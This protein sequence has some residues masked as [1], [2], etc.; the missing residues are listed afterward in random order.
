MHAYSSDTPPDEG[1][2]GGRCIARNTNTSST[3]KW[4]NFFNSFRGI[5]EGLDGITVRRHNAVF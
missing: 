3:V 1:E 4:V 2:G 5:S